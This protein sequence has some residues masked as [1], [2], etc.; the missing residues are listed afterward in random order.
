M[1]YRLL[2]WGRTFLSFI[3]RYNHR[4][5]LIFPLLLAKAGKRIG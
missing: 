2:T 3:F 5:E 1:P 4:G